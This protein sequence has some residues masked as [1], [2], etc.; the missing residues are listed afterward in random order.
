MESL[1]GCQFSCGATLDTWKG[2]IDGVYF[3]ELSVTNKEMT[4]TPDM[5][6]KLG[7]L[8]EVGS[9]L[10]GRLGYN[11]LRRMWGW[12]V[13]PVTG[14][15]TFW[16]ASDENGELWLSINDDPTNKV[17]ACYAPTSVGHNRD[18]Y[19]YPQQQSTLIPLDAGQAYYFEVCDARLLC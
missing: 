4:K 15:Y 7:S 8:L 1:G 2:I 10:P 6:E 18:W 3:S 11:N 13:P 12:L 16:I 19:L 14:N 9:M 17:R 5:T